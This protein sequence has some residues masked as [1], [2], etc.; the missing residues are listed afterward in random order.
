MILTANNISKSYK[1]NGKTLPVLKNIN[2]SVKENEILIIQGPSGAGK[3][4]LLHLLGLLDDPNEGEI[5]ISGKLFKKG[6]AR[7]NAK[8]R[9]KNIG[10]VFQFYNLLSDFNIL[11]NVCLPNMIMYGR[12]ILNKQLKKRAEELLDLVGLS[13]RLKH[14][15]GELSGGEQQRAAIARALINNPKLLLAD[16]PTGNLDSK[17][18]DNI[19]S[20]LNGLR[21]TQ[22]QT[23]VVVTHNE[24]LAKQ[25]DRIIRLK[26]GVVV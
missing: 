7:K 19:W 14:R 3:S 16:E 26:D 12:C 6:Q 24:E 4:T 1:I 5:N 23:I 10:F 11:E 9:A 15:P 22:V 25:G 21:K 20:L 13:H 2:L 18:A 17:N 8:F